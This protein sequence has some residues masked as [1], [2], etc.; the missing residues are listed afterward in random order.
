VDAEFFAS[1]T[2]WDINLADFRFSNFNAM[3]L[4]VIDD[5]A[6][7]IRNKRARC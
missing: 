7:S 1:T 3:L 6:G 2:K 5:S 4:L